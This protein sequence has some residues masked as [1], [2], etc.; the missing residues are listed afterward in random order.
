MHD[1]IRGNRFQSPPPLSKF[2]GKIEGGWLGGNSKFPIENKRSHIE[3]PQKNF[4]AS[5]KIK[6]GYWEGGWLETISTDSRIRWKDIKTQPK[7]MSGFLEKIVWIPVTNPMFSTKKLFFF[8]FFEFFE[9]NSK[10]FFNEFST[11]KS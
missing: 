3:A 6:G 4:F 11:K 10:F 1:N 8:Y 2:F 9:K 7:I 5:R